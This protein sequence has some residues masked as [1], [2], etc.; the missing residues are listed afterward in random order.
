V[1]E[2]HRGARLAV[3]VRAVDPHPQVASRAGDK[4]VL[5]GG[6]VVEVRDRRPPPDEYGPRLLGGH[7]REVGE[8]VIHGAHQFLLA[9]VHDPNR[10]ARSL[11][12]ITKASPRRSA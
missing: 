1:C 12:T 3:A 8:S 5:G 7:R 11:A 2:H 9:V 10:N 4:E 6:H